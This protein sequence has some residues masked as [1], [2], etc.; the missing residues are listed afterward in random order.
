MTS[1]QANETKDHIE[2][3]E[4]V[5]S[6]ESEETIGNLKIKEKKINF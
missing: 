4:S 6:D 1:C 2:D 3:S 5:N